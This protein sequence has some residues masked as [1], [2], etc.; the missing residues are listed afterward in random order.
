[1]ER[2]LSSWIHHKKMNE[3]LEST[4]HILKPGL[5]LQYGRDMVRSK[6]MVEGVRRDA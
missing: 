4:L 3:K 5:S 2:D 1:M 6:R